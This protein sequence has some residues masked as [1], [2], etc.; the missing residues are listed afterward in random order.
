[1]HTGEQGLIEPVLELIFRLARKAT[2]T[3]LDSSYS[4]ISTRLCRLCIQPQV[5][6]PTSRQFSTA[7]AQRDETPTRTV[8]AD[9]TSEQK[10]PEVNVQTPMTESPPTTRRSAQRRRAHREKLMEPARAFT[11]TAL[12]T[13]RLIRRFSRKKASEAARTSTKTAIVTEISEQPTSTTA[14]ETAE[15]D[16]SPSTRKSAEEIVAEA[17]ARARNLAKVEQRAQQKVQERAEIIAGSIAANPFFKHT[18]SKEEPQQDRRLRFR[19]E[20]ERPLVTDILMKRDQR[21]LDT[22][23][24][25]R[26]TETRQWQ[27][28]MVIREV[29]KR[30]RLGK[31]TRLARTERQH[32]AKSHFFKTSVKKLAPLAR[33]IA[34]KNIDDAI[35]QMRFSSKKASEDVR[36]ELLKARDEAIVVKGMGMGRLKDQPGTSTMEGDPAMTAALPHQ[37]PRKTLRHGVSKHETDIYI[38]QAWVNRGPYHKDYEFR[39][40]GRVNT[41]RPPHTGISLLLKEEKTRT[42]IAQEKEEKAIRKRMGQNM[43]TQLPDRKI[44]NQ[45]QHLLW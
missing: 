7:Q 25:P 32:L 33:Q 42:R 15:A 6:F 30:G 5:T 20:G 27:K 16:P 22:T 38:D 4:G 36:L 24:S 40:R 11:R 28:K 37:T 9:R 17:A 21:T 23:L 8:I 13:E 35:L 41:L 1:M 34:G 39:A 19:I 2:R 18:A 44:T 43:W 10:S 45:S 26:P 14:A 3:A 12:V 29:T 31:T